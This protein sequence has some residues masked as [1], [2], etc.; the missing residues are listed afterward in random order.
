MVRGITCCACLQLLPC[1]ANMASD[2]NTSP[3]KVKSV[4]LDHFHN[5]DTLSRW[6]CPWSC[7]SS[8]KVWTNCV[9]EVS[10]D[11]DSGDG[12]L[13]FV[14]S[15]WLTINPQP[16]LVY[17]MYIL[18]FLIK[19]LY[20]YLQLYL[21][22]LAMHPSNQIQQ[23]LISSCAP[24]SASTWFVAYKSQLLLCCITVS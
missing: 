4:T 3:L 8:Q 15:W 2:A 9:L 14:C 18:F 16:L 12:D 24:Y 19:V 1:D 11:N 23:C 13:V 21:Q 10:G 5:L 7:W 22:C 6:K 20:S 17:R